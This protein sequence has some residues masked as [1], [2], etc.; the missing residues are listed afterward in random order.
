MNI[1]LIT[2]DANYQ[3]STVKFSKSLIGQTDVSRKLDFFT[4]SNGNDTPFPTMLFSGSQGLGKTFTSHIVAK[5]LNRKL[6]EVNCG[7][8]DEPEQFYEDIILRQVQG[9]QPV[10]IL[11]DEAH[12]M[13][14][15]VG[16]EL[17]TI[18]NPN[19]DFSNSV[20]Y[21]DFNLVFDMRKINVI[22]ATTDAN[23]LLRPLVNRCEEIYFS[24][25][26]HS[27][28]LRILKLY[29]NG[30]RIDVSRDIKE[31]IGYA[32]R[33]RARTAF[34]L[35][36]N[37]R[38]QCKI[39]DVKVLTNETWEDLANTF[40]IHALGLNN[41]EV[42]LLKLLAKEGVLSCSSLAVKLGVTE[43]NIKDEWEQRPK[44]LGLVETTS[45][46]RSL[47]QNGEKYLDDLK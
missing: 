30:C 16:T 18:T 41:R 3:P 44:E 45:K 42:R 7:D 4:A 27:D 24:L 38:R 22:L 10:T 39:H 31:R 40:G 25:Y 34:L 15:K 43:D 6:V 17:L 13:S 33:G 36:Q 46:G 1:T 14:K 32:C 5:A 20:V 12:K 2:G 29:L 35:A 8:L 37:I 47:T 28:L 23:M 26:K 11:L 9:T 19:G 21:K